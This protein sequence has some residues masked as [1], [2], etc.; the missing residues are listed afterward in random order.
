LPPNARVKNLPSAARQSQIRERF[1]AGPGVSVSELAREF[2]VSEMTI[3]RDLAVLEGQSHIQR[4]HG[5]AFLTQRMMLEFDYRG[6]REVNRAAKAAIAAEARKLVQPGQRLILDTGTT[7][8]EFAALLKDGKDL[9]VIT[10]SL[11]VASELQHAA[12]VEVIL[13]GGV[14]RR[15]SPDLTGPVTENCLELFSADFAFQG[16]DGIGDDGAIYNSD[17]RL[18]RVDK[19]MRRVARRSCLLADHTK[20]G[21]TALARNG[22]LAD[23]DIFITDTGAPAAVLKRFARLG[24]KIVTASP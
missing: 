15:G 4:T 21:T 22:T 3:R 14:I 1:A 13:L 19:L 6:R 5:G 8:L 20:I 11:A 12:G 7:T 10:P 24:P 16:A 23:V 17:L 2:D 18:A 9:T